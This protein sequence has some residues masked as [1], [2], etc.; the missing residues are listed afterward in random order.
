MGS[1]CIKVVFL[2]RKKMVKMKIEIGWSANGRSG[3]KSNVSLFLLI[4]SIL[5]QR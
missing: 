4:S 2:Y 3:I 5:R 1:L